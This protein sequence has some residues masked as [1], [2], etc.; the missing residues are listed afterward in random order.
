MRIRNIHQFSSSQALKMTEFIPVTLEKC[1]PYVIITLKRTCIM[2]TEL[3]AMQEVHAQGVGDEP[4]SQRAVS[5]AACSIAF[6]ATY[7]APRPGIMGRPIPVPSCHRSTVAAPHTFS[8]V[9]RRSPVGKHAALQTL[10]K[11]CMPRLPNNHIPTTSPAESFIEMPN[12]CCLHC[13]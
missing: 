4:R 5:A 12:F 9:S 7:C 6:L 1:R 10:V 3:V 13:E 11:P 8:G 2:K